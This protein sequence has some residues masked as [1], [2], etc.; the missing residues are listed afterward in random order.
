MQIY[1]TYFE[2]GEYVYQLCLRKKLNYLAEVEYEIVLIL[3]APFLKLKLK[4]IWD[5]FCK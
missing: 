1:D 4:S 2:T 5:M 3:L